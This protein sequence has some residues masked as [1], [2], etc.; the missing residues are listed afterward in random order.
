MDKFLEFI[1]ELVK[2]AGIAL[3]MLVVGLL[4]APERL[5]DWVLQKLKPDL[6]RRAPFMI[7]VRDA[8]EIMLGKKTVVPPDGVGAA[9]KARLAAIQAS[10]KEREILQGNLFFLDLLKNLSRM[11]YFAVAHDGQQVQAALPIL[12]QSLAY[13]RNYSRELRDS[14]TFK[15]ETADV[16]LAT[17]ALD[18]VVLDAQSFLRTTA[19][20]ESELFAVNATLRMGVDRF[21]SYMKD[22]YSATTAA[23]DAVSQKLANQLAH[24][25]E[26]EEV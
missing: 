24:H 21:D 19:E 14:T 2:H 12:E 15:T 25:V 13:L 8:F 22:R 26:C 5:T 1:V 6:I 4:F 7:R 17:G 23:L 3:L 11:L 16:E 20:G 10:M 18:K 9:T